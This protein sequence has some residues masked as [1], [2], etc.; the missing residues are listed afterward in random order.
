MKSLFETLLFK[1]IFGAPLRA[2]VVALLGALVAWAWFQGGSPYKTAA[3]VGVVV[4]AG[5]GLISQWYGDKCLPEKPQRA[6]WWLNWIVLAQTA[7]GAACAAAV[8][9]FTVE[10]AAP[11]DASVETQKL[12][13]ALTTGVTT[14]ITAALVTRTNPDDDIGDYIKARFYAHYRVVGDK[15]SG[16]RAWWFPAKDA[17]GKQT[18]AEL[19]VYS[20][21]HRG[22]TTWGRD[23]RKRRAKLLAEELKHMQKDIGKEPTGPSTGAS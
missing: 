6:V 14:F 13:A 16:V 22:L 2:F 10:L 18:E 3:I 23:D 17:L 8:I 5:G 15:P 19:L 4:L 11:K 12:L 21:G 9:V 20:S 7:L 1:S